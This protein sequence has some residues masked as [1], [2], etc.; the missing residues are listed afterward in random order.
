ME[1]DLRKVGI[2]LICE[3]IDWP[4]CKKAIAWILSAT[5]GAKAPE[6]LTLMVCSLGGKCDPGFALIDAMQGSNIPVDTVGSGTVCSMGLGIFLAG[7]HR[8]LSRH[9]NV[10]SHQYTWGSVGKEHELYSSVKGFDISTRRMLEHYKYTTGLSEKVI[11]EKLLGPS[12]VWLDACEAQE[13][14]ICHEVIDV[15]VNKRRGEK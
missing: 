7:E 12:D 5:V 3:D 14:G 6:R 13:L 4:I 8:R 2:F 11:K 9:A 10:L 1:K 15:T